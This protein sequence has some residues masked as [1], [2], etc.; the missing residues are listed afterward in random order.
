M[1]NL[2]PNQV[3]ALDMLPENSGVVLLTRHS[4]REQ[5][6]NAMP[7]FQ[8]P[9]TEDGV[10]LAI[11]WGAALNKPIYTAYSSHSPR[12]VHTGEAM[13]E[14]AD[15]NLQVQVHEILCEPGCY[16]DSMAVAGPTFVAQGPVNFVSSTLRD[17]VDGMRPVQEGTGNFLSMLRSVQPVGNEITLCVTHDTILSTFVYD[18]AGKKQLADEDWPWMQEGVFLWFDEQYVHWIW[19]GIK[20]QRK[21]GDFGL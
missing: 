20:N 10:K 8:I 7:G 17:E 11:C 6:D 16:V 1:K 5:A 2:H 19:R 3:D 21:I 15:A 14:G 18:L 12:C 4:I 9:L 13:L